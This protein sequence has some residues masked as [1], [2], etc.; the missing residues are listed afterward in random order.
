MRL[1]FKYFPKL[2]RE[3]VAIIEELSFHTTKLY[4]IANYHCVQNGYKPY[5]DLEKSLKS[6]WHQAFLHSHTYQHCLMILDQDWKSYFSASR[7]FQQNPDKYTGQPRQPGY[8]GRD[9]KNQVVFTKC[10]IRIHDRTLKLS[11]AQAIQQTFHVKSLNLT[12]P[13]WVLKHVNLASVQQ[14]RWFWDRSRSQWCLIII[15]RKGAEVIPESFTNVMSIDLGLDNLGAITF[16]DSLAQYLINGRPLKSKNAW[17]NQEI[18]RLTSIR[19]KET[20]SSNFK[21]TKRIKALNRKRRQYLQDA[22]HKA[23]RW[24]V[25]LAVKQKC[26]TIDIGDIK[27]IKQRNPIKGFVQIPIQKLVDM[28]RYK[29]ELLGIEVALVQEHY[30]SGVS[31]YDLEPLDKRHYNTNRRI[32]RGL[33]RTND[34]YL[35]SSDVNGSLNILRR[36]D[37]HVVPIL[38]S[39]LRDNGCLNHPARVRI[40]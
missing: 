19:M 35:V 10:A 8:K 31:A 13:P 26:S 4:N 9:K 24:I 12:L 30:T 23:S 28:I 11:L 29:A 3:Q 2:N 34:G 5:V 16:K 17:Y 27:G 25:N 21:R 38:I 40:A 22:Q 39:E 20:G 36:H 1:T 37:K 18:A 7:D 33:F 15:Y 14:A 32:R 6:N